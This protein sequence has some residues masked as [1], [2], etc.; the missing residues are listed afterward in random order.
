MATL[1]SGDCYLNR[2]LG[3][4]YTVWAVHAENLSYYARGRFLGDWAG[5]AGFARVLSDLRGA[6][7]LTIGSARWGLAIC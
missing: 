1:L 7:D 4:R 5:P 6:Q 2:T 3:S